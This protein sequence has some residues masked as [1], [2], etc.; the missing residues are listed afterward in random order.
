M[1]KL[2]GVTRVG[3]QLTSVDDR[4]TICLWIIIE[5]TATGGYKEKTDEQTALWV[6][7]SFVVKK[8]LVILHLVNLNFWIIQVKRRGPTKLHRAL[9]IKT[10]VNH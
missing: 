8:K 2:A 7:A 5:K 6:L 3:L 9:G 10:L 4:A 1:S